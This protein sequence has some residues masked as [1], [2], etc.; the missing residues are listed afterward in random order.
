MLVARRY[1]GVATPVSWQ[2][3]GIVGGGM[4]P[5]AAIS[6][7]LVLVGCD[8]LVDI[9]FK[10]RVGLGR[11]AS[12][13]DLRVVPVDPVAT[14]THTLKVINTYMVFIGCLLQVTVFRHVVSAIVGCL[15]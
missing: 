4:S 3:V 15:A 5:V 6:L 7:E 12:G 9:R 11:S 14:H 1:F 2:I 13:L 8:A 10:R